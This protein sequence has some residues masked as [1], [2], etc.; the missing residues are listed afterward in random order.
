MGLHFFAMVVV[1]IPILFIQWDTVALT[2]DKLLFGHDIIVV[3]IPRAAK[4]EYITA[5]DTLYL[6]YM[7]LTSIYLH[8]M[9]LL[10]KLL[11]DDDDISYDSMTSLSTLLSDLDI[12][13][14]TSNNLE[15]IINMINIP[16]FI[17][18]FTD[19][20]T[21]TTIT[22]KDTLAVI[23]SLDKLMLT[24]HINTI[25]NHHAP[26]CDNDI[27]LQ[28]QIIHH[29]L[30]N[31]ELISAYAKSYR[32]LYNNT[33]YVI[34]KLL[35]VP[36]NTMHIKKIMAVLNPYKYD[37]DKIV[38][39]E[40]Y[41]QTLRV[42]HAEY[43]SKICDDGLSACT[44]IEE[45]NLTCNTNITKFAPF[46]KSL[47]KLSIW[48]TAIKCSTYDDLKFCTSIE[49]LNISGTPGIT[50]C[51]YFSESLRTLIISKE[52]DFGVSC[53]MT[54]DGLS[55]CRNIETLVVSHNRDITT[56]EP[57]AK[58]LKILEARGPCGIGDA[59]LKSCTS[60]TYLDANDNTNIS[61]CDPFA[62]SLTILSA[63]D[64]CKIGNNGLRLCTRI[65][66]LCAHNNPLI[67]TC[68]PFAKTLVKLM[69]NGSACGIND[70]GV[71][72]CISLEQ[73][74][75]R[76]NSKITTC[77][78]F[79]RTLRILEATDDC[80]ISDNGIRMCKHITKLRTDGNPR[81]TIQ[82]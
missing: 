32:P 44:A 64:T 3:L 55:L 31:D 51:E 34:N 75:A 43:N 71:R 82:L 60:I 65:K 77:A 74:Y 27:D 66:E 1:V 7:R 11:Y 8:P 2:Y 69:A 9:A 33:V 46:A 18:E 39:C 62:A 67:T 25:I 10:H 13:Q 40:P 52:C 15:N 80:G 50:T 68:E 45:L 56:C 21:E 58:S 36:L 28:Q 14:P 42:Y 47:K 16:N 29:A 30:P 70:N 22:I 79:A 20:T 61:T 78:P 19:A 4:N 24:H 26:L 59:A 23:Q 73:L 5:C 57:F 41:S 37:S 48:Q 76:N 12:V 72:Q 6:F 63:D 54:N 53:E 38:T 17:S 81:I 49:F 35:D